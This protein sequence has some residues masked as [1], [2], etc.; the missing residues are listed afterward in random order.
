MA[1]EVIFSELRAAPL[2]EV[3]LEAVREAIVEGR[4]APGR[5]INE[6]EVARQL[7]ISRAPLR[8]A[9]RQLGKEG[10]V[11]HVP[12]RGTIVAPLTARHV[13][14]LRSFRRLL[15][16]FA[17]ERVAAEASD[18]D[19]ELLSAV[20]DQ[21]EQHAANGDLEALNRSDIEFHRRL[22]E[23]SRHQLLLSV[24]QTHVQ[25]IR[26]VL[27]LRNRLNRDPMSIVEMHRK[28]EAALRA[29]DIEAVRRC[30]DAHGADLAVA[31]RHLLSE[32]QLDGVPA[33]D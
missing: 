26:R 11:S 10:L 28:L 8:E 30:Y 9:L 14:E 23:L 20:V 22:I 25:Q 2:S 29:R 18:D 17:A 1:S 6:V 27:A 33:A 32:E 3:A 19:L 16:E 12:Y 21:M 4:L 24:W 31:L 5:P 7:G 13:E 15:E